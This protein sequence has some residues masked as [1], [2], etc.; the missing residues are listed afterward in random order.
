MVQTEIVDADALIAYVNSMDGVIGEEF[1]EP[2]G[3]VTILLEKEEE[4]AEE[5]VEELKTYTV[6]KGDHL[7]KIAK[8]LLGEEMLWKKI[9]EANKDIIANP[10]LIY[11]GQTLVIPAE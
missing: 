3:N 4:P 2:A 10:D 6:V 9:Y 8:K 7:R 5:P 1:K 11:R